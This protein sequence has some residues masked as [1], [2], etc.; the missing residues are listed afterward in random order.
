[1]HVFIHTCLYT[2]TFEIKIKLTEALEFHKACGELIDWGENDADKTHGATLKIFIGTN[3]I[4]D[5]YEE[6]CFTFVK[7]TL[8]NHLFAYTYDCIHT[9]CILTY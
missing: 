6:I 3:T 9:D 5:I 1:M 4:T 8:G 7:D 2:C